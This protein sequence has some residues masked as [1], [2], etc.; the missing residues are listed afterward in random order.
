[1]L[2][3]FGG[4]IAKKPS[5]LNR[6]SLHQPGEKLG[7]PQVALCN[8]PCRQQIAYRVAIIFV[9]ESQHFS[10]NACQH[11]RIMQF[12]GGDSL[13]CICVYHMWASSQMTI[14][15]PCSFASD[16]QAI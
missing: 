3:Q 9:S 13:D 5:S 7:S 1:A 4:N 11:I 14:G 2:P 16:E 10:F 6:P 12:L 15:G 8:E